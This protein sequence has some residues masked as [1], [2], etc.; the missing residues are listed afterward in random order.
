L[1][2]LLPTPRWTSTT[3]CRSRRGPS[4]RPRP[5]PPRKKPEDNIPLHSH[6]TPPKKHLLSEKGIAG[7]ITPPYL[8]RQTSGILERR[9]ALIACDAAVAGPTSHQSLL[10][11]DELEHGDAKE[12]PDQVGDD[13]RRL[14]DE[15]TLEAANSLSMLLATQMTRPYGV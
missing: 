15:G 7:G 9:N 11:F 3:S 6:G 13:A 14:L 5:Q 2:R 8:S 1:F 10:E 4:T 12:L